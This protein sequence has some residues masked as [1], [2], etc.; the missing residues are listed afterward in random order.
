MA[1][2][3]QRT[4]PTIS[5]PQ[6]VEHSR[7]RTTSQWVWIWPG[8]LA[9]SFAAGGYY[10]IEGTIQGDTDQIVVGALQLTFV[11]LGW[12]S[13]RRVV[14]GIN[15]IGD[16]RVDLQTYSGR[17]KLKLSTLRSVGP[18]SPLS[19]DLL[20]LQ[21]TKGSIYCLQSARGL[22]RFANELNQ[23][24]PQIQVQG[25]RFPKRPIGVTEGP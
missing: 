18:V 23:R 13:I 24:H 12:F 5:D 10:L 14:T 3:P 1:K 9:A 19:Q 2:R 25:V 20:V 15:R 8:L 16:G 22:M 4:T 17:I 21:T 7:L 11:C 6:G